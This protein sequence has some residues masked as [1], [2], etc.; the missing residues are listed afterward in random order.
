MDE[1]FCNFVVQHTRED[2]DDLV[3]EI[4]QIRQILN[5]EVTK[6]RISETGAVF[7]N[8]QGDLT[9]EGILRKPEEGKSLKKL[10]S[11][12][13][14]VLDVEIEVRESDKSFW[15]KYGLQLS[16]LTGIFSFLMGVLTMMGF[17]KIFNIG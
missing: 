6:T 8:I 17:S 1:R 12:I 9:G 11:A 5:V 7:A 15:E 4:L 10:L 16:V 13:D 2:H 3:I 14:G